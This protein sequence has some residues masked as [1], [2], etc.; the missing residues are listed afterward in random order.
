MTLICLSGNNRFIMSG[1]FKF[2]STTNI[3][4]KIVLVILRTSTHNK[5]LKR[6]KKTNLRFHQAFRKDF[7][8]YNFNLS[9]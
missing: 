5:N 7:D 3:M 6:Y 8:L 9:L 2:I 1:Q 4:E